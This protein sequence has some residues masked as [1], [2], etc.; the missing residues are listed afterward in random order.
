MA[1]PMYQPMLLQ[2]VSSTISWSSLARLLTLIG[3]LN[4][5]IAELEAM[6]DQ[7]ELFDTLMSLRDDRRNENVK[8]YC[9]KDEDL[10]TMIM[11]CTRQ[12][13]WIKSTNYF[14]LSRSEESE[15]EEPSLLHIN[16]VCNPIHDQTFYLA[17]EHKRK[18]KEEYGV[19]PWTFEQCLGEAVFIPAGCPH[20]VRNLKSCTKVAIDFVS[21]ENVKECTQLKNEIRKLSREHKVRE[22]K[23]E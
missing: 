15:C 21:P 8:S 16:D 1:A 23:L 17:L 2:D 14:R 3:Q 7:G 9:A 5:L 12:R 11:L 10:F 4:A 19:E 13:G 20:Q 18:L 22:D 6:E